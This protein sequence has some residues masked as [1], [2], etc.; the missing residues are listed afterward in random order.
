[1]HR[2]REKDFLDFIGTREAQYLE[3]AS[4]W[5]DQ[6]VEYNEEMRLSGNILPWSY[7]HD[8]IQFRPGEVTLWGGD[9]GHGKSLMLGQALLFWMDGNKITLAS[10]EMKPVATIN[11]MIKQTGQMVD[12]SEEYKRSFMKWTD[13]RFW[14][15]DQLDQVP[16][17]RIIGMVHYAAQQLG[18]NIIAIDSLMK[19]G[20]NDDDYNAQKEFVDHLCWAAKNENVHIHLVM[21]TRKRAS[22]TIKP[23]KFD[24]AGSAAITNLADQLIIVAR[25]KE[26]EYAIENGEIRT[27]HDGSLEVR[28]NRHGG[29]EGGVKLYF[30]EAHQQFN[31]DRQPWS[32]PFNMNIPR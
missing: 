11:R 5:T 8:I 17:E 27:D 30:Q 1:M 10:L 20:I 15:Y 29:K 22:D 2:I 16:H 26:K 23:G 21:H 6:V 12:P 9:S 28:K 31:Q 19:C 3:P 13:D 7:T 32:M 14:I 25:N 24:M 18:C 4:H